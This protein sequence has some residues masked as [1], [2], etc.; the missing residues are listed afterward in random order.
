MFK[1]PFSV[2]MCVLMLGALSAPLSAQAST[3]TQPVAI[4]F[5][6]QSFIHRWSKDNLNEFTPEDQPDLTQW[7][8]M[9]SVN[10]H[11]NVKDGDQLAALA[12]AVLSN[13]QRSGEIIRADSKPRT[14]EKPAEHLIVAIL[15]AP[16]VIETAFARIMLIDDL[17]V[18][19][20][21]SR[22]A[23]GEEAANTIGAWLQ[24]NGSTTE[25]V[26]MDWTGFPRPAA[27][28][29]LPQSD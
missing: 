4:N 20:V 16:G 5:A 13:Y 19:L 11:P 9:I 12:N 23:Y 27:L 7:Q 22:R 17:G 1:L 25:N 28:Q 3:N 21:Y 8:Q 18:I 29:T 10:V 6:G 14:N 26:L 24:A 15:G 2:L